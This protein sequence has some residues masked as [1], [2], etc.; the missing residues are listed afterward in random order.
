MKTARLAVLAAAFAASPVIADDAWQNIQNFP[1]DLETTADG[2]S[3]I[4]VE[5]PD[6]LS[7]RCAADDFVLTQQTRLDRIVFYTA[8]ARGIPEILGGDVYIYEDNNNTP[9]ALIAAYPDRPL[10][11]TDSGITNSIFGTIYRN[12]IALDGIRLEPGS[13]YIA[14]RTVQTMVNSE[15]RNAILST[16]VRFGDTQGFWAFDVFPNG[17]VGD[18]WVPLSTFNLQENNDWAFTLVTDADCPADFN[19]DNQIDFFDYLDF[20]SAFDSEDPSADF[21]GDQQVDFFDYL[22]F[23]QAF[24]AGCD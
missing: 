4:R 16:R 8:Y 5:D 9:G 19:G 22:D 7:R 15:A 14:M 21:N 18:Q 3:A 11:H 6:F 24:D 10:L 17:N 20:A 2:W 1:G 23:V 12:E 13:Y